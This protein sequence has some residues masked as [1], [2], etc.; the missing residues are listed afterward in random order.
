MPTVA[1]YPDAVRRIAKADVP[2]DATTQQE[3]ERALRAAEA[4]QLT[5]EVAQNVADSI[6]TEE[7]VIESIEASGELPSEDELDAIVSV[8][9][10]YDLD[11]RVEEVQSEI[12]QRVATVE[13]VEAAIDERRRPDRPTFREE[14]QT[15]VNEVASRQEF[16]GETPD[17][18]TSEQAREIGAPRE[19][20]FRREATQT[21]AQAEQVTPADVVEG[22]SA[23]TPVQIIEDASGNAVAATGGPSDE[24]GSEVAEEYG[25]DYL[26]TEDVVDQIDVEGRGSTVDLTLRGRRVGE[27]EVE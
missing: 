1:E 27:V 2:D 5:R 24:I 25:V 12:S 20:A 26:S 19:T 22:T 17:Q 4:P 23:Q 10:D 7:K 15:A 9:D 21:I 11:D 16:V 13:E 3:V 18:V 6:V 14:V 8:A